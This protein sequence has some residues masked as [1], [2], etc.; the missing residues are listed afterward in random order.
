[1]YLVE[2]NEEQCEL[3]NEIQPYYKYGKLLTIKLHCFE[4][5][6]QQVILRALKIS[7][8]A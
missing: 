8:A 6:R 5:H 7:M 1:M 3:N 4:L 2:E